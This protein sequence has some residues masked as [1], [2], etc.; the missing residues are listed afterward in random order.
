MLSKV[1]SNSIEYGTDNIKDFCKKHNNIKRIQD[2]LIDSLLVETND[3]IFIYNYKIKKRYNHNKIQ[4]EFNNQK[5]IKQINSFDQNNI[6]IASKI[7]KCVLSQC[8][9]CD[10]ILGIGGEYYLYFL[11]I[12]ANKYY[13]ISNHQSIIDDANTNIQISSNYIVDYNN[14][15]SYPDIQQCNIILL[16]VSNI[17]N[18]II[19]YITQIPFDKLI[20]ITCNIKDN[21]ILFLTNNFK[22]IKINTFVNHTGYIK[23]LSFIKKN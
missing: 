13:G 5:I 23:I 15:K 14:I 11:F 1:D 16:N 7:R 8:Y 6:L 21:K 20:I 3:T 10:V 4:L 12:N 19:L 9:D 2:N 17:N 18:N 22:I